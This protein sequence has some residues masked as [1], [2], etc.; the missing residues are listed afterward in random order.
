MAGQHRHDNFERG[1]VRDAQPIDLLLGDAH[2]RE[3]SVN[4]LPA[5]VHDDERVAALKPGNRAANRLNCRHRPRA[6]H[7]QA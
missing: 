2:A 5:T 1:L 6:A 4:I 3:G 7:R